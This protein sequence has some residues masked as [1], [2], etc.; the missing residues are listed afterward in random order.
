MIVE[1]EEGSHVSSF[2][3][4]TSASESFD[5]VHG[6]ALGKAV[7]GHQQHQTCPPSSLSCRSSFLLLFP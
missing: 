6:V 5:L 4:P 7:L 1:W 2:D 3:R